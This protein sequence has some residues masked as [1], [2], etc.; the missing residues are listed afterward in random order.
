LAELTGEARWTTVAVETAEALLGL[1]W[2]E[3]S[4]GFFTTG[5]DAEALVARQQDLLDNATP[6]AN[7]NAAVA[8]PASPR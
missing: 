7:S 2:D 8:S 6:S 1:F 5:H 4:A 3:A